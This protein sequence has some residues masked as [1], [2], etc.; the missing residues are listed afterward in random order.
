MKYHIINTRKIE[1][2]F[3]ERTTDTRHS[4]TMFLSYE[5]YM[6]MSQT[7][8]LAWS[9]SMNPL[10]KIITISTFAGTDDDIALVKMKFG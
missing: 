7:F 3:S 6:Y 8:E 10:T 5:L 9:Y 1:L 2:A 4:R